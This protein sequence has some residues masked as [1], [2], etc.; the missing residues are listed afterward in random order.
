MAMSSEEI[1]LRL[2]REPDRCD[3]ETLDG[4]ATELRDRQ[5]DRRSGAR[6]GSRSVLA[7]V[8]LQRPDLASP[9][10]VTALLEGAASGPRE[11][12]LAELFEALLARREW[13]RGLDLGALLVELRA[14]PEL[15]LLLV[16]AAVGWIPEA[17]EMGHLA[18]LA[19][20]LPGTRLRR[21]LL[22][23][24]LEPWSWRGRVEP[25][26][27]PDLE[28]SLGILPRWPYTAELLRRRAACQASLP[29]ARRAVGTREGEVLGTE[30]GPRRIL[31]VQNLD[32]GQGDEI[33]RAGT[34][35]AL[36]LVL[37]PEASIDLVTRRRHLYDHPRIRCHAIHQTEGVERLISERFDGVVWLDERFAPEIRYQDGLPEALSEKAKDVELCLE[38]ATLSNHLI[39]RRARISSVDR[40]PAFAEL[41][42]A[43][44]DAY[45]SLELFALHLGLPWIGE[46]DGAFAAPFIGAPSPESERFIAELRVAELRIAE[47]RGASERPLA[48]VQPFGGFAEIK[49]YSRAQCDRLAAELD[50]LVAEGYRVVV[51]PT[52][53]AWGS[54][55]VIERA[56]A[57]ARPESRPH[58]VIAPDPADP[59]L[60]LDER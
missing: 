57:R 27:I 42:R 26:R 48:V 37:Y 41:R 40:V 56:F 44:Y 3:P 28:A 39:F 10:L 8:A 38:A 54:K 36:L 35:L 50:G 14:H 45:E 1:L 17:I 6:S 12:E 52:G 19:R 20:Q 15:K 23:E 5:G 47:L 16:R 49:G 29:V 13:V 9:E 53:T 25:S 30:Q 4:L 34:L 55:Q 58:L 43:P 51:L 31:F 22:V 18:E 33:L 59:A 60:A 32:I 24:I 21:R 11:L 46:G 7:A 2:L